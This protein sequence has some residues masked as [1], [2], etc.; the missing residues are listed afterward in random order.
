MMDLD[1]SL[2]RCG[3]CGR[4]KPCECTPEDFR[5]CVTVTY[6]TS[7]LRMSLR[8]ASVGRPWVPALYQ[9]GMRV[10]PLEWWEM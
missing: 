8:L 7:A 10:Y 4:V 3:G 6:G 5:S 1:D 9:Q 2:P